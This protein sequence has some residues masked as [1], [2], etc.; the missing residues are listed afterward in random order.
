MVTTPLG[1]FSADG[2]MHSTPFGP[3]GPPIPGT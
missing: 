2:H 1:T 3:S